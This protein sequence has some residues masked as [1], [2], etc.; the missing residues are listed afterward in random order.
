MIP[1]PGGGRRVAIAAALL[2][3]GVLL[4]AGVVWWRSLGLEIEIVPDKEV[5]A[6]GAPITGKIMVHNWTFREF[7][8]A[9][10]DLSFLQTFDAGGGRAGYSGT[11]GPVYSQW[12]EHM[13]PVIHL[14]GRST[15]VIDKEFEISG[16]TLQVD[17]PDEETKMCF[18]GDGSLLS[19]DPARIEKFRNQ[20]NVPV[21][22]RPA[23]VR[24][25]EKG[26]Q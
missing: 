10:G 3:L 19:I 14:S 11:F 6:P 24:I 26:S 16:A 9:E 12:G 13:P 8:L 17:E 20:I 23:R 15:A 4:G 2:G 25:D 7:N 5:W 18:P 1:R 22:V 21:T